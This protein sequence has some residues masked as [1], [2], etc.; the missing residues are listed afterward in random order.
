MQFVEPSVTPYNEPDL[1]KK[2][3]RCF[4]ICYKS[5]DKIKEG[6]EQFLTKLIYNDHKNKHW[7]PL[8][9]GRVSIRV[10]FDVAHSITLWQVNHE[11]AFISVRVI[12][13][14]GIVTGNFRAFMDFIYADTSH[15]TDTRA[16]VEGAQMFLSAA[17]HEEFPI[18]F[19]DKYPGVD[20]EDIYKSWWVA[21]AKDYQTFHIVTTRDVLQELARHRSLSFSVESTRYCNY[22]KRGMTF[23]IPRPYAWADD[24]HWDELNDLDNMPEARRLASLRAAKDVN[25]MAMTFIDTC[26]LAEY[27]YNEL[28]VA[29]HK[30]QE[31]R[32]ILPGGLK[33]ELMLTGTLHAWKHFIDLR[34]D[35]AAHPQ[36]R[37]IAEMICEHLDN[38][39]PDW[40]DKN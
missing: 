10:P 13:K 33:T 2:V 19:E 7:S 14:Y 8:E 35:V 38:T 11:S 3:E 6:S 22:S 30:P 34:C 36:I 24:I 26:S 4:R 31:A 29:G 18:L 21:E 12:D 16:G 1:Q 15:L 23:T 32:M 40:Y 37:Y 17:L 9:H 5:E 27:T 20:P 25:L 39:Y 28:I